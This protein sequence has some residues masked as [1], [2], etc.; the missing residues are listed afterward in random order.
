MLNVDPPIPEIRLLTRKTNSIP[1][2][3][4]LVT[5]DIMDAN[6][7]CYTAVFS[8]VMQFPP[9]PPNNSPNQLELIPA[10]GIYLIILPFKNNMTGKQGGEKQTLEVLSSNG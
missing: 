3:L 2:Q 4:P 8:V 7:V 6:I 5:R 10:T 1:S 9:P